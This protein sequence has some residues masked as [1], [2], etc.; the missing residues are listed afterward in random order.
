MKRKYRKITTDISVDKLQ[1][2]L[3]S[4]IERRHLLLFNQLSINT[5]LT[6]KV[7]ELG[8]IFQNS[9]RIRIYERIATEILKRLMN[10]INNNEND[11]I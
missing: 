1:K 5:N 6:N 10:D 9:K 7:D 3:S 11:K 4:N 2:L 8:I